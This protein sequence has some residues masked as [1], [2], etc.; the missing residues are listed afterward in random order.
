MKYDFTSHIDRHGLDSVA[1]DSIGGTVW[2]I[3]PKAAKEGYDEIPMWVADMNFATCPS[4]TSAIRT[5][6]EHPLF[7]YFV[8]RDEYYDA[9]IKWQSEQNGFDNLSREEIGYENGVHGGI[10]SALSV[11]T[12]PGDTVLLH[13]PAYVGFI[14]DLKQLGRYPSYS[15]LAKDRDG[16]WRMDF[17]DMERRI[18]EKNIHLAIFCSPHNPTG[19][20]WEK[21]ELERAMELFA[22]YDVTVLSDEIWSDIIFAGQKHI[23]T[24]MVSEDAAMRTISF[25]APSKTFNLAGMIGSYHIIH[26][27]ELR[28]RIRRY[29]RSLCYNEMNIL[30]MYALM[31]AY[32]EEGREWVKE[33]RKVLEENCR[34]AVD[35]INK[36]LPG[37]TAS[38][39]QGTYMIFMDV[40][41][42]AGAHDLTMDEIL[43]AGW[44][45]G[46]AYQD[47]R[48]FK[49]PMSIR[50]NCALP[51][52]R[53]EEAMRRMKELVFR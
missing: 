42:Y 7:G 12:Q 8:P 51:K 36:E 15:P 4:I 45:V 3:E 34:Y 20:V 13:S 9:V 10:C 44:R 23:P 1:V 25:Y 21:W 6:L 50:L 31:G 39:P 40:S 28:Q 24:R 22:K 35:F 11:L 43:D 18:R 41:E 38:M 29:E 37:C 27:P 14:G 52:D 19:R 5:R 49:G 30:S 16:I 33:L 32:S 2:G 53:L 17:E 26:N 47:G 46:V 48:Q